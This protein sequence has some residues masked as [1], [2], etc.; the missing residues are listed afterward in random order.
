MRR[1]IRQAGAAAEA[2]V[3]TT[4]QAVDLDRP[5]RDVPVPPSRS[6]GQYARCLVLVRLHEDPLGV[7]Q[8]DVV[9]G[10]VRALDVAEAVFSSLR[11]ELSDHVRRN[12]CSASPTNPQALL[13]AGLG[14]VTGCGGARRSRD[15][16]LPPVALIIPTAGRPNDIRRCLAR[17]AAVDYP[18]LDI[19]VVDNRPDEQATRHVVEEAA[20]LDGRICYVAEGRPGSSVARNRGVAETRA[21]IV[22]FTDDDVEVDPLWVR[23]MV[24]PFMQ[25]EQV[26]AV[27]GLVLPESYDT[28]AQQAFE[29]YAG[30][31]KG[32]DRRVYDMGANRPR[33]QLLYPYWGAPFGSGNSMAFRRHALVTIGGFDPALGAG[34][35]ALAGADIESFTHIVL[36]GGRLVYEPRAVVW[37]E[38][39]RDEVALSQQLFN[40]GVGATA[41]L[42]KWLLRDPRMTL[43]VIRAIG[44]VAAGAFGP[45]AGRTTEAPREISRL[46]RQLAMSSERSRLARQLRGFASGPLLYLRSRRWARRQRLDAVL[47]NAR[48]GG[49]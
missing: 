24:E 25:D 18:R 1:N 35:P 43:A 2:F 39:R 13:E 3:A 30:F 10:R 27:T 4:S 29:T 22:A 32:F 7:V 20:R 6:G 11:G 31:G 41:I 28:P 16:A 34:S 14:E 8:V 44:T 48:R 47:T 36:R 33:G 21:D 37:H 42:T 17:L 49:A 15:E 46:N 26:H 19:I 38:H 9:E 23:W 40:Y 5:L 45:R 12:S